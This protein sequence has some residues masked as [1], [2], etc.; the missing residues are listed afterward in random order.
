MP[1]EIKEGRLKPDITVLHL[2]GRLEVSSDSE[3]FEELV[4]WLVGDGRR[5]SSSA[6]WEA[7]RPGAESVHGPAAPALFI[8]AGAPAS[9]GG[10]RRASICGRPAEP[11]GK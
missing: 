3:R 4:A 8:C 1:L 7:L 9:T 2:S 5:R 6:R 11:P 10:P